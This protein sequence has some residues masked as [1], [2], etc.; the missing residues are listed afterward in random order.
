[1]RNRISAF[2]CQKEKGGARRKGFNATVSLSGIGFQ[3][4]FA[5]KKKVEPKER[6][7][8]LLL[9]CAKS[10]SSFFCQKEKGGAKRKGF[11][12]TVSLSG[13]GFQLFFAEKKR[14]E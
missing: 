9:A 7:L 5:K 13:I 6:G 3:L 8:V 2:L 14:V 1:M 10:I 12:A 11:S 4:F